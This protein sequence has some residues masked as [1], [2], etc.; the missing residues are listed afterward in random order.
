MTPKSLYDIFQWLEVANYVWFE[1][2]VLCCYS[3]VLVHNIRNFFIVSNY[4]AFTVSMIELNPC[5]RKKVYSS[6]EFFIFGYIFDI[7]VAEVL[8]F[9]FT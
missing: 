1:V 5:Q 7:Q 2:Q 4:F 8:S 6:P 9:C 3:D